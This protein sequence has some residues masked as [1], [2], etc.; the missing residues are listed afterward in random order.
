MRRQATQPSPARWGTIPAFKPA[1]MRGVRA[2][3]LLS[4]ERLVTIRRLDHCNVL[5][6]DLSG[7]VAFYTELLEMKAG[8]PPSGDMSRTVWIYDDEG[9][10]ILHVQS[11]D[12]AEPE[13]RFADIRKR[14]GDLI[15][16][17][18]MDRLKD[19]GSI[20]HV[21]LQCAGYE[22]VKKRCED[23]GV[24]LRTNL[25]QRTGLRQIFIK[26]PNGVIL[27]LNFPAA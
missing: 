22:R 8:P 27:E 4:M 20:E 18:N 9:A 11:V 15:D 1:P 21:A 12:P 14:L 23:R 13:T 25:V 26:D 7:T 10:P 19:T 17:L 16:R 2:R 3:A 24:P 6:P 5:T